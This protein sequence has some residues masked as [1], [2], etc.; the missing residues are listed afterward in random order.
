MNVYRLCLRSWPLK[1]KFLWMCARLFETGLN[2]KLGPYDFDQL[3]DDINPFSDFLSI[4]WC[5]QTVEL[6]Q[7][8]YDV[9]SCL[10]TF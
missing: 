7:L 4:F 1:V 2:I 10:L 5:L 9:G 3:F 6:R 8:Q